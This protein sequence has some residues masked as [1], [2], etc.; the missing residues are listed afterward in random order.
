MKLLLAF[1]RLIRYPNLLYIFLTQY[2]LQYAVFRPVFARYGWQPSLG[3]AA[4]F[5]LS[6]ST[7]LIAA[8][9]YIIN[10]YFDVNTDLWNK[11]D[12]LIV[13]RLI[14]RRWAMFWHSALNV[15]GVGIGFGLAWKIGYPLLGFAQLICTGLLWF[16]STS[17]KRQLL[18]GNIVISFLTAFTVI[19]VGL[20]EPKIY[21][22]VFRSQ[23]RP[24]Y[25]LLKIVTA[26]AIFAFLI[27]LVRE[28]IKDLEDM[29]GDVRE[30]R[31]TM[32]I[33]YGVN[34][35]KDISYVLLWFLIAVMVF[36][37]IRMAVWGWYAVIAYV[38]LLL[39]VPLLM[40]IRQ[41]RKA[42]G[43]AGFRRTGNFIKLVMLAGILSMFFLKIYS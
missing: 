2:L 14:S 27:S 4:F 23:T 35:C 41:L 36:A 1:L 13:D 8:A 3:H 31:R 26:Y 34:A 39:Q 29:R 5:L 12:K 10:D 11:P 30:G 37:E 25:E 42:T 28:I 15:I 9:G 17:Y 6:L 32:P 21:T 22:G 43:K 19:V 33:V 7:V 20:Y 40:T 18:I 24:V 38:F 16:Y